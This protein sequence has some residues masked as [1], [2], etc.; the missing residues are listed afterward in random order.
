MPSDVSLLVTTVN[1]KDFAKAGIAKMPTTFAQYQADL[2]KIQSQG[3]VAHPLDIPFAAAE[4][5]STYW[6]EMTAAFGGGA[7][8]LPTSRSSPRRPRA[9]Y[10]AMAWMVGAYKNGLVPKG[11]LS[12]EDYQG[13]SDDQAAQPH[14]ERLLG[15]FRR[16]RHRYTTSRAVRRWSGRSSTSRPRGSGAGPQPGQPGRDRRSQ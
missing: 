1:T 6:Y 7:Q 3:V 8:Q 4:G 12:L 2:K 15:L 5:L 9:G 11:N 10:K 14:G 16:H 13:F